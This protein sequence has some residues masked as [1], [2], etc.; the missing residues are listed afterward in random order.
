MITE[1]EDGYNDGLDAA[2]EII[3]D[4]LDLEFEEE[5]EIEELIEDEKFLMENL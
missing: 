1:Y 5:S 2:M 4:F 3:F